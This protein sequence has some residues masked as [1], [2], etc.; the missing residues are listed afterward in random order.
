VQKP[1][2]AVYS[3]HRFSSPL[4]NRRNGGRVARMWHVLQLIFHAALAITG[5][6]CLLTAC[7]SYPGEEG[8]MQSGLE[9][10]WAKIDDRQKG[11]LS[12]HAA[13]MQQVAKAA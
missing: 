2:S 5:A 3:L 9:D 4:L 12:A 13:F 11:L 1:F 7:L 10:L 6:F 8:Q